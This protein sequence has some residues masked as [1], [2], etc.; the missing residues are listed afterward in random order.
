MTIFPR[1]FIRLLPCLLLASW[2]WPLHAFAEEPVEEYAMLAGQAKAL[3][4]Q[5]PQ[6]AIRQGEQ[7]LNLMPGNVEPSQKM[8]VL[9]TLAVAYARIGQVERAT[10]LVEQALAIGEQ[11][12]GDVLAQALVTQGAV[13]VSMGNPAGAREGIA[14]AL[15]ILGQQGD[16]EL[17]ANAL[18]IDGNIRLHGG[19]AAGAV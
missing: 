11:E 5:N 14:R 8:G 7:A 1:S 2:L 9:A 15:A 6:E 18:A 13:A 19:D 12:G 4:N 16:S 17:R 3:L 10:T